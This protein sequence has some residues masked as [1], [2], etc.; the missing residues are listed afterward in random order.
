MSLQPASP[1]VPQVRA[2]VARQFPGLTILHH[3]QGDGT[4]WAS[5]GRKIV[6]LAP[7][8]TR[9]AFGEFPFV[10]KRD[11]LGF[12]RPSAR[13]LRADK[14]NLY[15]N[16]QGAVL[17]IRSSQVFAFTA[18]APPKPLFQIQGDSVLHGSLCEDEQGWTYFGE[19]FM[20]PQRQSVR[21]YR[22]SPDLA[23][24]Q[25][26]Y[27]FPAGSIRHIHGVYRDPYDPE[28]LW[29]TAGDYQGE[30]HFYRSR[31]RFASLEQFGDGSQTWR[32]VRL[33]FTPEHIC[34]LTDSQLEQNHA[35]RI[36]RG[37]ENDLAALEMGQE[38]DASAWYGSHTSD[39]WYLSFT[40]IEP[41]PAIH[42]L[43]SQVLVSR[44]AF[45]W[46]VALTFAKD[47]WR[48]MKVFKYGVISCPSGEMDSQN[49]Y[50]SGEGLVGLDGLSLA[51]RLEVRQP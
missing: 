26:A 36:A 12:T 47:F 20:N 43:A 41:G 21:I 46:Q 37:R 4:L 29:V 5:A 45:H 6:R 1:A 44:D 51:L 27:E 2:V 18:A 15:V 17:G 9:Q 10:P 8:G 39:G 14:C 30:C 48:P 33:F 49:L 7:D 19:Y 35:C 28:A 40:T 3:R 42:S 24:W 50:L 38:I 22:L 11:L 25:V 16:R 13:A 23:H 32:A 31:D 34:W